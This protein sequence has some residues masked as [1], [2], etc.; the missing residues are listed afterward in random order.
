MIKEEVKSLIALDAGGVG[1]LALNDLEVKIAYE[2]ACVTCPSATGA[3][4]SAIQEIL[5][6]QVH[7]GLEVKPDLLYP[8]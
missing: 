1:V 8:S 5:R 7:P 2:G 6:G 3:T 4:L